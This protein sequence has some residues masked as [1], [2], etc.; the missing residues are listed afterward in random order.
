MKKLLLFSLL[1]LGGMNLCFGQLNVIKNKISVKAYDSKGLV[2][3]FQLE[4]NEAVLFDI[5]RYI[6][7]NEYRKRLIIRGSISSD[8]S[9]TTIHF[10]SKNAQQQEGDY[11]CKDVKT[12]LKPFLGVKATGREDL[13]GVDIDRVVDA[14]PAD[15]AGITTT[16]SITNFNG[17]VIN[18]TCDLTRA[19]KSSDIGDLV[20][21]KLMS[22][23]SQYSKYVAIGFREINTVTYKYC[24]KKPIENNL[25]AHTINASLSSFPNPTRSTSYVNFKSTSL[26]NVTFSVVDIKGNLIHREIFSDFEGSLQLDYN[27]NK[28]S[29]GTYIFVVQQGK[30]VYKELVH[31]IK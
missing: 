25:S 20:E 29:A 24:S 6:K 10:D 23:A 2:E 30:E 5:P 21:I 1:F 26:E 15:N 13:N 14:T 28:D 31:L 9:A 7:E 19:V 8:I 4:G 22:G 11:L 18:S 16:E 12:V 3:Q 17:E 27:H